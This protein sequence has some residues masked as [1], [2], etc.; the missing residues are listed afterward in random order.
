M[1]EKYSVKWYSVTRNKNSEVA[2]ESKDRNTETR[3]ESNKTTAHTHINSILLPNFISFFFSA[4]QDN[5]P[6]MTIRI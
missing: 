2:G 3:R 1:I 5:A 4:A 6:R